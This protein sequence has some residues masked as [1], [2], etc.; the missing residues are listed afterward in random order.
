MNLACFF[1]TLGI[2]IYL[3]E[4][5]GFPEVEVPLRRLVLIPG[6]LGL[7]DDL[8]NLVEIQDALT[9]LPCAHSAPLFRP[10]SQ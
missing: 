3:K 7:P 2:F 1:E 9:P 10:K 6:E 8:F 5:R 4:D